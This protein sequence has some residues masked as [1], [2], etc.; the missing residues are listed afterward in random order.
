MTLFQEEC[1]EG[2]CTL[3]LL[4]G[5]G[6]NSQVWEGILAPLSS[7]FKI[8]LIDLPGYGRSQGYDPL[9]LDEMAQIIAQ[10]I[11][12]ASIVVGWSLGGLVATRLALDFPEK[13][14]KLVCVASSPCFTQQQDWAGISDEVLTNFQQQLTTAFQRT[15]ERFIALQTLGSPQASQNTKEL[16]KAILSQPQANLQVLNQGLHILQTTDLRGEL[17]KLS[18]PVLRIYGALDSL[19]PRRSIPSANEVWPNSQSVIIQHAAHAP[20]ISHPEEF[21]QQLIAFSE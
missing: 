4:H 21:C 2:M 20:F 9:S 12:D 16:K 6:L 11:P 15:I 8:L 19:I 13:V 10:S 3:V 1:G 18:L 17:A 7:H 14:Q 5:W